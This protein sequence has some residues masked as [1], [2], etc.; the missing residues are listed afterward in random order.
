M[1]L[2]SPSGRQKQDIKV[3]IRWGGGGGRTLQPPKANIKRMIYMLYIKEI[4]YYKFCFP[5]QSLK[6]ST[7]NFWNVYSKVFIKK[8]SNL[9]P[10]KWVLHHDTVPS[11]A[12]LFLKATSKSKQNTSI[13]TS[14]IPHLTI[15]LFHAHKTKHAWG[16]PFRVTWRHSEQC[17]SS[18]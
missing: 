2:E 15:C 18:I 1:R 14:I 3:Y 10:K 7:L 16:A 6:H 9:W 11:N 4:I 5:K 12:A 13:G 8:P 17:D